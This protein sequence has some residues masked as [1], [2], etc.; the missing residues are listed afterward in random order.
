MAELWSSY[1]PDAEPLE[2]KVIKEYQE[3]GLTIRMLTYTIG[4]FKGVKSKMAGLVR[5]SHQA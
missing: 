3:D 5:F 4:T 1:D 2:V